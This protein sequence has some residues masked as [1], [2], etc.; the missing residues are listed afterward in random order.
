[1]PKIRINILSIL[2]GAKA[3]KM[4]LIMIMIFTAIKISKCMSVTRT[5]LDNVLKFV[6]NKANSMIV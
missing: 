4:I 3:Q 1:M 6:Y 5:F 2:S